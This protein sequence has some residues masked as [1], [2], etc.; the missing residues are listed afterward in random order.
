MTPVRIFISSVMSE[1]AEERQRLYDYIR[2]DALLKLFFEPYLFEANPASD[3]KTQEIFLRAAGES[4][5]YVGIWGLQYGN[6]AEGETSPTEQEFDAATSKN[7]YRLIFV[8]ELEDGETRD[9]REAELIRRAEGEVVRKKFTDY[10]SLRGNLYAALVH[11]LEKNEA[12]RLTPFDATPLDA[13]LDEI[14]P[15][16]VEWWL[17]KAK[18]KHGVKLSMDGGVEP[19]LRHLKLLT[20]DGRLTAAAILLFGRDPQKFFRQSEVKCAQFYGND[21]VKPMPAYHVYEGTVFEMIDQAVDFVMSRIDVRIGTRALSTDVPVD[22]ELPLDAVREAI[23]N[24]VTHREYNN[25]GSVQVML[26]R[27]RLLVLNPG[28]LPRGMTVEMLSRTHDSEPTNRVLANAIF[29]AGYIE[30]M[31]TGTTDIIRLCK[32]SGLQEP[33][34]E[35]NGDFRVTIMRPDKAGEGQSSGGV[36]STNPTT[37]PTTTNAETTTSLLNLLK[38]G[39]LSSKELME[40]M[41]LKDKKS[42]REVYLSRALSCGLIEMTHP[43]N[44][45]H[46]NQKY[47]LTEFGKDVGHWEVL[48]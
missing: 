47:R 18:A 23:V 30:R 4:E 11:Y 25:N 17:G 21:P 40:R 12:L 34:Y 27:N 13:S 29:L 35:N 48:S 33:V 16:K 3:S 10:E 41:G 1:F 39:P 19:I 20:D 24:A 2:T 36:T 46:R 45:N 6:A 28:N 37:N 26:F 5:I 31:G 8:K 44:Q 43:E 32:E 9:P 7:R 15:K 38:G 22:N 42:F 14:D